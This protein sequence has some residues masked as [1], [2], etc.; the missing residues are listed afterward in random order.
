MSRV[1]SSAYSTWRSVPFPLKIS[2]P[3]PY[4]RQ[5]SC[6]S[7]VYRSSLA[8]AKNLPPRKERKERKKYV[9]SQVVPRPPPSFND[10]S[11]RLLHE[12]ARQNITVED[13]PAQLTEHID[14]WAS[15]ERLLDLLHSFGL[16][17][18]DA[19]T[20][21]NMF[22][23][24]LLEGKVLSDLQYSEAE[25]SR[26]AFDL[27]RYQR[28]QMLKRYRTKLLYE[29]AVHPTGRSILQDVVSSLT[30]DRMT[31]LFRAAD[32]SKPH[33]QHAYTR[34]SPRRKIVMHV[35]PTNSGKT[36][37][38][39][40]ALAS[41]KRGLYAGPLR[42]LA[43][44][45]W[46]RLN[47]GKIVPLEVQDPKESLRVSKDGDPKYARV[48]NMLTGEEQKIVDSD[49]SL[50]SCTIE[51]VPFAR[52]YDVAVVDEI[53]MITSSDR[54]GAWTNAVLGILADEVHL[55]GEETAVPLIENMLRDTGDELVVHRYKRLT[56]LEV[57]KTPLGQDF[58]ALER[59]DCI[60]TFSQ[61]QLW[62]LKQQIENSTGFR[63]A[64]VYGRLP[65]ETRN[66]QALLF[67]D[68]NSGYDILIGSDAIGMGLN[69]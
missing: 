6:T 49:A 15:D 20:I 9:P 56:P 32:L 3:S 10:I 63:C 69:L 24:R 53:Q 35:G 65:P 67:N 21:M 29:W 5:F 62:D 31:A 48:C 40:R 16:T 44:E 39:L 26:M 45:I 42:L 13:I 36:H 8:S 34:S 68:P 41:A 2:G 4:S 64:V 27:S 54:G 58:K 22:V 59:G 11:V 57:T 33:T 12:D 55:C 1:F 7:A 38:A 19:T 28:I 18:Q 37:H 14:K 17:G 60:V 25:L 23:Q 47:M 61:N 51:M 43:H 46:E 30:L 50:V 52:C 66:D